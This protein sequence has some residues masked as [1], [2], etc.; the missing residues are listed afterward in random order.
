MLQGE[1]GTLAYGE[2]RAGRWLRPVCCY[3]RAGLKW[4]KKVWQI[5]RNIQLA[6]L[7]EFSITTSSVWITPW[8]SR[9][10]ITL[11]ENMILTQT[12]NDRWSLGCCFY[13][14]ETRVSSISMR[15]LR[16]CRRVERHPRGEWG[17][18]LVLSHSDLHWGT[19]NSTCHPFVRV[20]KLWVEWFTYI[21]KSVYS[22]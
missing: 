19:R 20:V 13:Q 16:R 18:Q 9:S 14:S 3:V 11:S 17:I 15:E 21:R 8:V 22:R 2:R 6:V 4:K 12:D 10:L 5:K 1:G 7:M